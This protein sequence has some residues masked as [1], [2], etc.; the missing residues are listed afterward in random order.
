MG[1]DVKVYCNCFETGRLKELPPEP[2]LVY[3]CSDGSLECKS[4]DLE[5]LLEF[6]EWLRQRA[7]EHEDGVLLHHRI[8]NI[9]LVGLLREELERQ[10]ARFPILLEKVLYS[11]AHAGDYLSMDMIL[12]VQSEVEELAEFA[13]SDERNQGF[14]EEFKKQMQG[15]V[16]AALS[17][18]KPVSF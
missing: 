16:D 5:I 18:R 15:L 17:V 13:A 10:A 7:C 9:A 4:K 6:D 8:G 12:K 1:L 11:S 3:V 2:A 14:V